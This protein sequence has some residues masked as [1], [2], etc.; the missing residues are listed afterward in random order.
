MVEIR[1]I[2]KNQLW[3][4]LES[5]D[6]H[7]IIPLLCSKNQLREGLE[8][9]LI[10]VV[11]F[12]G[13]RLTCVDEVLAAYEKDTFVGTVTLSPVG[14]MNTGDPSIIGLLVLKGWRRKG[15]GTMI[16]KSAINRMKERG[17]TPVH[18]DVLSNNAKKLIEELD[19]EF[20]KYLI[21]NDQSEYGDCFFALE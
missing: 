20:K 3:E 11:L 8:D 21:V 10:N 14:E 16:M 12:G 5:R 18:I 15:I 17:L 9:G 13:S 7:V 6:T 2:S 1:R 19:D 4:E